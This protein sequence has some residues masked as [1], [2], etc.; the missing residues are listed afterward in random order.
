MANNIQSRHCP[1]CNCANRTNLHLYSQEE[2]TIAQCMECSMIYLANPP[3]Y[4]DLEADYSWDKTYLKENN[5]RKKN[6]GIIKN[7]A[8]GI[9]NINYS[10]RQNDNARYLKILGP[11][12]ILDIGCGDVVRWKAPFVPFGIEI[13]KTLAITANIKMQHLGGS[14]LQGAG[15]KTIWKFDKNQFDSIFMHSYLEHEVD[16]NSILN[17]SFRCLKPGGRVFIR[18]P[19]FNSINRRIARNNW[20]GL[21]YPDHVNYFTVK[22]LEASAIKAKFDFKLHNKHKIWLDDNIQ[23]L[24]SKPLQN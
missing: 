10:L 21:R 16:I 8:K 18:V 1:I 13:S 4:E 9:R 20:P 5:R 19:N 7:V 23:A 12:K 24:L 14:C 3:S 22:T 2:W 15:A 11:G 17:G 6:R